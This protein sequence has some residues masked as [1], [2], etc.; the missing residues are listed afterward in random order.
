LV[1]TN[2]T[3]PNGLLYFTSS[4]TNWRVEAMSERGQPGPSA[5][6][7]TIDALLKEWNECRA[8]I[9]R[10]E[11]YLQDLR[12]FGFSLVTVLL[13]ASAFLGAKASS[14]T[15]PVAATLAVMVLVAMLFS[16]D[17]YYEVLLNGVVERALD[18]EARADPPIQ[19][20]RYNSIADFSVRY[21]TFVFYLLLFLTALGLGLWFGWS[22]G[23]LIVALGVGIFG[24]VLIVIMIIYRFNAG[25]HRVL[26][27]AKKE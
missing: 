4:G 6:Q 21:A 10:Y 25:R 19:V 27:R 7:R 5:A 16:L 18:L 11:N 1:C 26:Y 9:A 8:T 20:T 15:V 13:T 3:Y 17:I 14:T 22:D 24:V 2:T 12:K 23:G